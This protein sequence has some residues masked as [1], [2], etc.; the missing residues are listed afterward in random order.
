MCA[1]NLFIARL[2]RQGPGQRQF[3]LLFQAGDGRRD[4]PGIFRM[5]ITG[6]AGAAL[7]GD[8]FHE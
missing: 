5:T 1:Q 8:D 3:R 2:A 6:I 7:I 4:A